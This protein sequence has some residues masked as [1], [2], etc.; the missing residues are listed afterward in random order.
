MKGRRSTTEGDEVWT[1]GGT[2]WRI[3]DEG[4][5]DLAVLFIDLVNST[6]FASVMG[7][8]E[9]AQLSRSFR[10]ACLETCRFFFESQSHKYGRSGRHFEVGLVGDELVVYVHTDRSHDDVYQLVCLAIALKCAWL[11]VPLNSQ[12]IESG[13][14]SLELAAGIH[15]GPVWAT[16]TDQGFERSGFA[17]NLAKRVESVSREGERFRIFLSDPAFKLLNLRMRNLIL[18]SR[19]L[20]DLKGVSAAVGVCELVEAFVDP[21]RRLPPEWGKRF[22]EVARRALQTNTFD[23]WIHS[24]LQVANGARGQPISDDS[25]RLCHQERGNC[26][27]ACLYLEDLTRFWPGLGDGWL[28]LARLHKRRGDARQARRCLL[29]ARRHGVDPSEEPLEPTPVS[30]NATE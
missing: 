15:A 23:L 25:L 16:R 6:D 29:H 26:D 8:E 7:L 4:Q 28:A 24:C 11:G 17:I 5:L 13:R 20:L 18:G 9:Y 10:S 22:H 3:G 2:D 19:R 21:T 27:S 14:P 1:I 30:S 12:R